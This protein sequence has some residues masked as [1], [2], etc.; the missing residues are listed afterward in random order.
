[1]NQLKPRPIDGS[2][3]AELSN[4]NE[5]IWVD[6]PLPKPE[7]ATLTYSIS[8]LGRVRSQKGKVTS[9]LK[10][11]KGSP[12]DTVAS[13]F[14]LFQRRYRLVPLMLKTF[15]NV[16]S[17][18]VKVTHLDGDKANC[19]LSN[20]LVRLKPDR[21]EATRQVKPKVVVTLEQPKTRTLPSGTT[22]VLNTEDIR[23][24]R[25]LMAS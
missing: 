4:L 21:R 13:C 5:E 6:L 7:G 25:E 15:F 23:R 2:C 9:L 12:T 19:A 22:N 17:K 14:G 20:L 16:E 1:M 10:P 18:E 3:P 24:I 11:F 8:N